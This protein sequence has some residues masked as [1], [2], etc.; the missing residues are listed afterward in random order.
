[1]HRACCAAVLS[2]AALPICSKITVTKL[3]CNYQ[4]GLAVTQGNTRLGWQMTS[5]RN[6]DRQTAYQ[7]MVRENVTNKKVFDSGRTKS[8]I[9]LYLF[10]IF[11][12]L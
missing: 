3:T 8:D 1:M 7:I 10:L 4:A 6:N 9:T 12:Q 5:D 2:L 11:N